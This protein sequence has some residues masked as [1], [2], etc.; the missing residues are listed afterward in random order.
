[1]KRRIRKV[2]VLEKMGWS[3]STLNDRIADGKFPKPTYEG[4]IPYWLETEVDAFIDQF[5]AVEDDQGS[6]TTSAA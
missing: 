2:T 5:F 6:Q 4:T 1:M 3:A